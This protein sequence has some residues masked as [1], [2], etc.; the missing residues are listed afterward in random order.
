[1]KQT[2]AFHES[3]V[4]WLV[5]LTC[6]TLFLV[7]ENH[8]LPSFLRSAAIPQREI[9][10]PSSVAYSVTVRQTLS[11]YYDQVLGRSYA[12]ERLTALAIYLVFFI[13]GPT[14]LFFAWRA[15]ATAGPGERRRPL[16]PFLVGGTLTLAVAIPAIPK[17]VIPNAYFTNQ[18]RMEDRDSHRDEIYRDLL[19]LAA[20][21]YQYYALP[22]TMGGGGNSYAGYTIR[23]E[24]RWRNTRL[25][26][27]TVESATRT[28]ATFRAKSR[29]YSALYITLDADSAGRVKLL[30]NGRQEKE[31]EQ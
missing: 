12:T 4:R 2:F 17:S 15:Y 14:L 20:D 23:P 30:L 21:A 22:E 8:F 24:S 5:V 16:L 13:M 9:T 11:E 31:R 27:F 1:M 29:A 6:A 25:A 3:F 7:N 19:E 26:E 18:Q 10:H 28:T